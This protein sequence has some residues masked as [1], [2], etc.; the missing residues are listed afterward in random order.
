MTVTSP[1]APAS[2]TARP[3]WSRSEMRG[4]AAGVSGVMASSAFDGG[5]VGGAVVVVVAVDGFNPAEENARS[6]A[7][8]PSA[9]T[10]AATNPHATALRGTRGAPA[11][12]AAARSSAVTPPSR[13]S[14]SVPVGAVASVATSPVSGSAIGARHRGYDAAR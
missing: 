4:G 2:G 9:S 11:A 1:R 5:I 14:L 13:G 10:A 3:R 7:V 12:S 8:P 6:R